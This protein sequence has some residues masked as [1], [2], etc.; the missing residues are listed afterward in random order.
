MMEMG[1]IVIQNEGSRAEFWRFYNWRG[2]KKVP[3]H[4]GSSAYSQMRFAQNTE[5]LLI[6]AQVQLWGLQDTLGS[7]CRNSPHSVELQPSGTEIKL[8]F[9]NSEN[10]YTF[11]SLSWH[12]VDLFPLSR[13]RGFGSPP[14]LLSHPKCWGT[15][16]LSPPQDRGCLF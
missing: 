8:N 2:G 6:H 15:K 10:K 5:F 4:L 1:H 7:H 11:F 9:I 3:S 12:A 16:I 13:L 14:V